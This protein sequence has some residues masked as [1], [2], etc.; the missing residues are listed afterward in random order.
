MIVTLSN[1]AVVWFFH[2]RPWALVTF[3]SGRGVCGFDFVVYILWNVKVTI[4]ILVIRQPTKRHQSRSRDR[5]L[6]VFLVT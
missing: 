3:H 4:F 1:R 2:S 5:Y 6:L